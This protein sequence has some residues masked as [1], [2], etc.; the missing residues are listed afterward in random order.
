MIAVGMKI[1]GVAIRTMIRGIVRDA[2]WASARAITLVT[3]GTRIVT[4][5]Q[6]NKHMIIGS[7]DHEVPA[8]RAGLIR[9]QTIQ[10]REEMFG[11]ETSQPCIGS[12]MV[13]ERV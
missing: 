6:T 5:V 10:S 7:Y 3:A 2:V 13:A 11:N 9:G 4:R 8:I 12:H 1:V